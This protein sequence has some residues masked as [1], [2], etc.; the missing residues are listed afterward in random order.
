[1]ALKKDRRRTKLS[2]RG[3]TG[4]CSAI[5]QT[6]DSS[7]DAVVISPPALF[8]LALEGTPLL[9]SVYNGGVSTKS[10]P[11]MASG[12][13]SP[14]TSAASQALRISASSSFVNLTL[15]APMF[16]S[17]RAGFVVPGIYGQE[18]S[19]IATNTRLANSLGRYRCPEPSTT[20]MSIATVYSPWPWQ[21]RRWCPPVLGSWG[22]SLC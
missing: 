16:S 3:S 11:A 2:S 12:Y 20:P 18:I 7:T 4:C 9:K 22:S 6:M 14:L 21:C 15:H 5:L 1:M 8:H 19:K 17:T 13:R 10:A